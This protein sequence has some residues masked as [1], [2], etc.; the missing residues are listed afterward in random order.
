MECIIVHGG[1]WNI[2]EEL[3]A[4]H[5]EGCRTAARIGYDYR[6]DAMD[7]VVEAVA[8]MEE[9]ITFDAGCGSFLNE[10]GDV[11]LDAIVCSPASFGS[12]C[13]VRR[14]KSPVRLAR[15]V[16]AERDFSLLA[17]DG[18]ERYAREQGMDLVD[19]DYFK[20]EREVRRWGDLKKRQFKPADAFKFSTVGAVAVDRS[21]T[22]AV[23]VSTGGT[24][25]KKMGRIGDTPIP[26]A[27]AYATERA[28][29]ASTGYGEAILRFLLA[30]RVC[31]AIE[32]EEPVKAAQRC[33]S[34]MERTVGGRG[35][36]ICLNA[37]GVFGYAH[38]TPY[39]AVAYKD[40]SREF[41][42]V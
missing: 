25:M 3:H 35:G 18:T 6:A 10:D 27:G 2:P 34:E 40:G 16:S 8:Y 21:G 33:V 23:A 39:M 20:T 29:V 14:V 12:V 38:T 9:D 19:N 15:R 5:I 4:D 28:G 7:A 36:V 41:A 26:G 31:D 37:E 22:V 32:R 13:A 42:K 1:A 24:P 11:E 30:K 17:G